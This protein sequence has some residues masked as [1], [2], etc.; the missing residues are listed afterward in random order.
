[1]NYSAPPPTPDEWSAAKNVKSLEIGADCIA[2]MTRSHHRTP[3][4]S[5]KSSPIP[6]STKRAEPAE[7]TMDTFFYPSK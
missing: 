7:L 6:I 1:M 2:M 5:P 4:M 3:G